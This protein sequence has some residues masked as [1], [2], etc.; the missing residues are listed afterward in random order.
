MNAILDKILDHAMIV[1][2]G[3]TLLV[4]PHLLNGG[5]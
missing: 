2:I 4:V 3:F 5:L 1:A